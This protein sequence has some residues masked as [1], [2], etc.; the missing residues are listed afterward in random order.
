MSDNQSTFHTSLD[1]T[2]SVRIFPQKNPNPTPGC[3]CV[4]CYIHKGKFRCISSQ[5]DGRFE[6]RKAYI[7]EIN[8]NTFLL[9]NPS[10][11]C[12]F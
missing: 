10:F 5:K 9:F 2:V 7:E 8:G 12:Y 4:C 6:Y 1:N 11:L 3:P